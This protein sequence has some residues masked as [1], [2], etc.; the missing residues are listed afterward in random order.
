ML[1]NLEATMI[2]KKLWVLAV[3]DVRR[4]F[5][6]V[7]IEDALECHKRLFETKLRKIVRTKEIKRLL[8][9]IG[10]V[11]RGDQRDRRIGVGQGNPY[12]PTA[13]NVVMHFAHDRNWTE[14]ANSR[15]WYRYADNLVY[16]CRNMTQGSQV[17]NR[18][19]R[20]LRPHGLELKGEDG[21]VDLQA[22]KI[23]LIL[24]FTL[25]KRGN[26][27]EYDL[28]EH[29][30]DHLAQHLEQA[31]SKTD[32]GAA[33]RQSIRQWVMSYGP[34]FGKAE[35]RISGILHTAA[36]CGF[37][38][39]SFPTKLLELWERSWKR[40]QR[41]RTAAMRS[42]AT[43]GEPPTHAAS[44]QSVARAAKRRPEARGPRAR[45]GATR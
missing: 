12:S 4:A 43:M 30:R 33:A 32:P 28:G 36:Q 11:L 45:R 5:D 40:W 18:A 42:R 20:L 16:A 35:P 7:D 19:H 37:R 26:R 8:D 13:L 10:R 23:A 1:A 34:A 31:H 9:L 17:L 44:P 2:R 6:N 3:E 25:R 24:G 41:L 27:L 21:V 22:G 29:S 38:E 39:T 15:T 14:T